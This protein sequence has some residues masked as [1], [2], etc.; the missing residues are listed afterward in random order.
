M[1]KVSLFAMTMSGFL[2]AVFIGKIESFTV[3]SVI[4]L[5][6]CASEW[7]Y[8]YRLLTK[9]MSNEKQVAG[10]ADVSS[11]IQRIFIEQAAILESLRL[12][13]T[14]TLKSDSTYEIGDLIPIKVVAVHESKETE[15]VI[16]EVVLDERKHT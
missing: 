5:I 8:G 3:V 14:I 9:Y 2:A 4:M 6:L 15:G 11:N 7:W 10:L 16:Y 13:P 12:H 1:W